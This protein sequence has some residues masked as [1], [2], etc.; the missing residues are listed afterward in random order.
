MLK[1]GLYLDV[2]EIRSCLYGLE[3]FVENEQCEGREGSHLYRAAK[4]LLSRLRKDLKSLKLIAANDKSRRIQVITYAD[5]FGLLQYIAE[6]LEEFGVDAY[7][8]ELRRLAQRFRSFEHIVN[9]G[10]EL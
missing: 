9:I 6:N 5:E 1:I 4:R 3:S 8:N 10:S 7:S 2:P